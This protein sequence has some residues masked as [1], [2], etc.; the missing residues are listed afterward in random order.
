L[1]EQL[2]AYGAYHRDWRN[3][4]THFV[5]VPLVT[6]ALFVFLGWLRFAP[7]PEVP[8]TGATLFYL[9]VFLYYLRL[10]WQ[11]AL[12]QA[13][14]SLALLLLAD[15]VALWPFGQSLAVFA[16]AFVVGWAVQLLG[17]G[18][19]GRR[20]AL[21][22]NLLQIF[23]APLFLTVE[24]L[25]L[26]GFR[27]DLRGPAGGPTAAGAPGSGPA[28]V[29]EATQ[30]AQPIQQADPGTEPVAAATGGPAAER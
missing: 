26:A 13:P 10:D 25:L 8:F 9:V 24:V 28:S 1:A 27:Q 19:E 18:F 15:R 5:G 30:P 6:F 23:N 12:L 7:A 20:P 22:D 16:A 21:A 4:L 11:V 3:K 14:F 29:A 2:S 17:H